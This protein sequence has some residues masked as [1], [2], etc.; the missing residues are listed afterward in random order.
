MI[1][2]RNFVDPF[3]SSVLP[4]IVVATLLF[5]MLI[6]VSKQSPK[7]AAT[8]F[9]GGDVLR[10]G[11]TLLF[12]VLVAQVNLRS[13]LGSNTV[14]Y[15]E[16]FYFVLYAAILAVSANA[17]SFALKEQGFSHYRDIDCF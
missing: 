6:M 11:V 9:K 12:P 14:I 1:A 7:V 3:V 15:I 4:L 13:R 16:Y 8:G 5:G 10:A 2:E 17:L